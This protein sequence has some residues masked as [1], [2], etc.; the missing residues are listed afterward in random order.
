MIEGSLHEGGNR[1][2]APII[3]S[4][5]PRDRY[6]LPALNTPEAN[7]SLA[8][9][10]ALS[11][12][13]TL[14]NQQDA[15]EEDAGEVVVRNRG[16]TVF[17]NIIKGPSRR[18]LLQG[19]G[20]TIAASPGVS[21]AAANPVSPIMAK[22]SAF[23]SEAGDRAL[24]DDVVE[25]AK[26]HILDTFA[27]MVSGSDLPPARAAYTFASSYTHDS[28]ATIVASTMT[29]DPLVAALVNGMLAHSDETDDSNEFSRSHPGCAVVPAAFAAGEKFGV[30]GTRFLRAVTLGYDI[31]PRVTLSFGA[32]AYRNTVTR[33]RTPSPACLVPQRPRR[34]P[35]DRVTDATLISILA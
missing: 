29:S 4:E 2:A 14:A 8:H 20:C 23:M 34:A 15:G 1:S 6:P 32:I 17:P 33:A 35:P 11:L 16:G 30:G 27:A 18:S 7:K 9:L 26:H 21:F 13:F 31:G 25:K 12:I 19:V 10:T 22:L 3:R 5:V 24:P 28:S